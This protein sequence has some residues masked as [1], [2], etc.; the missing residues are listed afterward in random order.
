MVRRMRQCTNCGKAN[1]PTRK[2]CIRCGAKLVAP[3]KRASSKP[4]IAPRAG[5]VTTGKKVEVSR[6]EAATQPEKM[7]VSTEDRWVK[8]SEVSRDR[9]R[10]GRKR[11][12]RKSEMEK[13]MEAFSRADAIGIE[14]EGMG[15]VETRMLR[16]SDVRE[17][18]E[19]PEPAIPIPST[20]DSTPQRDASTEEPAP[21]SSDKQILG[22]W[23]TFVTPEDTSHQPDVALPASI[24]KDFSSSKYDNVLAEET[25]QATTSPSSTEAIC[26]NCGN[27]MSDDGFEY[28]REIYSAMGQARLKQAKLCVVQGKYDAAEQNIRVAMSLFSRAEDLDGLTELETLMESLALRN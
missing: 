19:E 9:V 22:S 28:P 8:P 16:A 3:K 2:F 7:S 23:S 25:P 5:T 26:S 4:A 13:A 1:Q 10:H 21:A 14:E 24:S 18:M 11:A 12:K 20:E 27:I 17:L 15:V 6:T